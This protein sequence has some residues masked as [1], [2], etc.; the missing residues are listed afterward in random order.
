MVINTVTVVDTTGIQGYIF[1]TNNL[2][3]NIGASYLVECVTRKWMEEALP[4]P[5]NVIDIL[6]E[7]RPFNNQ[8]IE[9]GKIKAEVVYAGGG[10][11]VILFTGHDLAIDFAHR[12]TKRVLLEAPG[13]E[14]IIAHQDFNW[15]GDYE[16]SLGGDSGI[17]KKVMDKV[18]ERKADRA[19]SS[20]ILGL[21]VTA[22]CVFTGLPAVGYDDENR[23]ISAKAKAKLAAEKPAHQRL[24]QVLK[25][26]ITF[27]EYGIPKDFDEFG[28]SLRKPSYI[29]IVH[30]DG[31]GMSRRI[32]RLRNNYPTPNQ[33]REYINK[34]RDF[35]LSV[36]KAARKAL[37]STAKKLAQSIITENGNKMINFGTSEDKIE[38]HKDKDN[39]PLFPFRPIV[40]GGDDVTFVCNGRLGLELAAHYLKEFSD[41][42]LEDGAPAYCRAGVAVVKTHYPFA[43]AYSL[44]EELCNS[45]K[46]YI[47]EKQKPPYKEPDLTAMDWHFSAGGLLLALKDLRQKEYTTSHGK[48]FMRPVWITDP[49]KDWRSWDV[50]VKIVKEF[51]SEEWVEHRNKIKALQDILR[52]GPKAVKNF[53]TVSEL[54][55]KLPSIPGQPEMENQGW[56]GGYCGYFDAIEARD[57]F[58]SLEGGKENCTPSF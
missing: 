45:A 37:Q 22:S 54:R 50:F 33:N 23:L 51:Q 42:K 58:I 3:Q 32:A 11:A 1:G 26:V 53:L 14:V 25:E 16:D 40:F 57:F 18:A 12:L 39:R 6:D 19:T 15:H 35:S 55:N 9:D 30:T 48:L 29:A 41:C 43:R 17:I 8:V 47:K 44:A 46:E 28:H 2:A 52:A 38:L 56:Q 24:K 5:H 49:T 34:M 13:L 10:N 36:Q 21:G 20:P 31:N 27:D 4:K 7:D